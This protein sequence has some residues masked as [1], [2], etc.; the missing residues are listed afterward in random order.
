MQPVAVLENR[1]RHR[2]GDRRL[3]LRAVR[4]AA[5]HAT[6]ETASVSDREGASPRPAMVAA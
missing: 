2:M 5:A 6:L 3:A 4:Q 1:L